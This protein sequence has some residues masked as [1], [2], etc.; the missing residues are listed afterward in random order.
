MG[1]F[2]RN[3]SFPKNW[4]RRANP[5]NFDIVGEYVDAIQEV[6]TDVV[7][8]ANNDQGVFVPDIITEVTDVLLSFEIGTD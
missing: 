6:H 1:S 8:G 3:Q 7:P 4:H 2:F 5:G